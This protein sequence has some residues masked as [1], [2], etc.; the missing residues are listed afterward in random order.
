M[1]HTAIITDSGVRLGNI[2]ERAALP[3]T[4]LPN[5]ITT[6]SGA[7]LKEQEPD[8]EEALALLAKSSSPPILEPPTPEMY[9]RA[10]TTLSRDADQI[11]CVC[12]SRYLTSHWEHA[13]RGAQMTAGTCPIRLIDSQLISAGQ[14]LA[15]NAIAEAI[16]NQPQIN[17]IER[18]ARTIA[19][20]TYFMIAVEQVEMLRHI[21]TLSAEH[22][23]F[24]AM[25]NVKPILS[26]ESGLLHA[27][28]KARSRAHAID[29]LLEF[30][31]EF[32][33]ADSVLILHDHKSHD[34]GERLYTRLSGVAPAENVAAMVYNP[35]LAALIG[36]SAIGIAIVTAPTEK[37]DDFSGDA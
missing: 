19:A 14:A 3:V 29:R 18:L 8:N 13:S 4:I 36:L 23:L 6:A 10:F 24:S 35:S 7:F 31:T 9:A 2:A 1:Q 25:L 11:V 37:A 12:P 22:V 27:V 33:N 26:M 32:P 34:I 5:Q 30:A 16:A 15:T 21:E 17:D 28:A 20:R